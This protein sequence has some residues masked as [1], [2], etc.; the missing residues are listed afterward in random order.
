MR[1]RTDDAATRVEFT[2]YEL[3]GEARWFQWVRFYIACVIGV[4]LVS[5]VL[6]SL[7]S[8]FTGGPWLIIG[9][10]LAG[11]AL[12]VTSVI[13]LLTVTGKYETPVTPL[14]FRWRQLQAELTAPR[15][16]QPITGPPVIMPAWESP[17][18]VAEP[19]YDPT[20][21]GARCDYPH[22]RAAQLADDADRVS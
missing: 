13:A 10:T 17:E 22:P 19:V 6:W 5:F 9:A 1:I 4:P 15:T 18:V 20:S 11:T 8:L 12:T 14:L 3:P 21:F 7:G 2:F 16:P